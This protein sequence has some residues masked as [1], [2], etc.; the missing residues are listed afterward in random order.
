MELEVL[1]L[2]LY[3]IGQNLGIPQIQDVILKGG[4]LGFGIKMTPKHNFYTRNGFVT[5]RLMGLEVLI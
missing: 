1:L 3:S 5:H 2:S 4:Q